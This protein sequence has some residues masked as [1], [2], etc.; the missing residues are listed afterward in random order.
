MPHPVVI[1]SIEEST[2]RLGLPLPKWKH[3]LK[4]KSPH[5]SSTLPAYGRRFLGCLRQK[6]PA[7]R[8]L[9]H[10]TS[11][12]DLLKRSKEESRNK[13]HANYSTI[14]IQHMLREL[15]PRLLEAQSRHTT[16]RLAAEHFGLPAIETTKLHSPAPPE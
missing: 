13:S 12:R 15:R 5:F 14:C 6:N 3:S 9:K 10:P 7:T 1:V 2:R 11:G 16:A 4:S 8:P